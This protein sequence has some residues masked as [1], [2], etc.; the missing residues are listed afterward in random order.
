MSFPDGEKYVGQWKDGERN[1]RGSLAF[2]DGKIE[3]GIWK[4]GKLVK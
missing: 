1:G 4:N 2:T 3:K